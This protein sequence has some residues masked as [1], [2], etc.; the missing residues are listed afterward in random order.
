MVAEYECVGRELSCFHVFCA[1]LRALAHTTD[2]VCGEKCFCRNR[3]GSRGCRVW[4]GHC[5]KASLAIVTPKIPIMFV[6]F[7]QQ[8]L[9]LK[10]L[11]LALLPLLFPRPVLPVKYLRVRKDI[12]VRSCRR[13]KSRELRRYRTCLSLY[14]KKAF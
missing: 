5:F 2:H 11:L 10:V 4:T 7:A 14:P 6:F 9:N 12:L 8:S 3:R 1:M 13:R